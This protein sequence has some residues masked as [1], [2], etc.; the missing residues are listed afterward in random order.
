MVCI[1]ARAERFV[2][3]PSDVLANVLQGK[4]NMHIRAAKDLRQQMLNVI[5]W[6]RSEEEDN[7]GGY[8]VYTY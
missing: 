1:Y 2:N 5:A 8:I 4:I 3:S 6:A 7:V